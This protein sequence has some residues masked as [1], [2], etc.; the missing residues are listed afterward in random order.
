MFTGE[1]PCKKV[2]KCSGRM[3]IF[4]F[5]GMLSSDRS[6]HFSFVNFDWIMIKGQKLLVF[7]RKHV[8]RPLIWTT[9]KSSMFFANL[10]NRWDDKMGIQNKG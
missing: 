5:L 4:K 7:V 2:D 8:L 6:C 9:R 3:K 10:E 1:N